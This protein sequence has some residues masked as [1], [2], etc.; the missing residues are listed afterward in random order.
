[1]SSNL[2]RLERRAVGRIAGPLFA[3]AL[4]CTR[5]SAR[6]LSFAE[7]RAA[8]LRVSPE[9][10][11]AEREVAVWTSDVTSAEAFAN[12]N[13]SVTSATQSAHLATSLSLP[14]RL[15]GQR[16]A[17]IDAARADVAVAAL[18][19]GVVRREA[20]W[21]ASLA[22]VD[23]WEAQARA[24]WLASAAEDSRRLAEI[25]AEKFAA[26]SGARLDQL[27]TSAD[28]ARAAAESR[29]AT[30]LVAAAAARLAPTI[31][32][33][34]DQP[35][36]A[37]GAPGYAFDGADLAQL[38]A[39]LPE[40]P[41]LRRARAEVSA[42]ELHVADEQRKRWPIVTPQ[43]GLSQFDPT[44]PGTDLILGLAFE[45]PILDRRQGAIER[46]EAE[47]AVA[48]TAA[49]GGERRLRAELRDAYLRSASARTEWRVLR[50]EVLPS[51]EEAKAMTD[52]GYRAGYVDLLRV[53]DAQ[54]A[55]LEARMAEVSAL[56][57]WV[58]ALADL[59]KASGI[60]LRESAGHA[61]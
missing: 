58:R 4:G 16:G 21:V 7:A 43:I 45:L 30:Q 19:V 51:M 37:A 61:P 25:A 59:E 55:L 2:A 6:E 35:L 23:L 56:A 48:T 39:R 47:R 12:P 42:S 54:R 34:H 32:A 28:R 22:Y 20:R 24:G 17:S 36:R 13:F 57:S 53:L 9:V 14:I 49:E 11:L 27:R 46:A 18:D 8:A 33:A 10:E 5:V 52:E 41:R 29:A 40:H 1:M 60:D 44:V 3:L 38:E 31:G 50:E 15:F 26:G